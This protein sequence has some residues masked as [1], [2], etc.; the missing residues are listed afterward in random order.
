MKRLEIRFKSLR[1]KILFGFSV[2]ILLAFGLSAFIIYSVNQVN[3]DLDVMMER[4]MEILH[5][6]ES[7]AFEMADSI[8]MIRGYILYGD[9]RYRE[10]FEGRKEK[11]LELEQQALALSH[12]SQMEQLLEEKAR[13]RTLTDNF[14]EELDRGNEDAV[15]GIAAEI[16]ILS[17]EL[18]IGF[19]DIATE[20]QRE[21]Q[22]LG[23]AIEA[24]SQAI[25]TTGIVV[26]VIIF[27]IGVGIAVITANSISRPIRKVM[28]RMDE[29]ADGKLDQ[30]PLLLDKQDETGQL[31]EGLNTMQKKMQGLLAKVKTLSG[32]VSS[33]SEELTQSANEV[34][35]SAEQVAQTMEE[36]ASGAETQSHRATDLAM[37]MQEFVNKIA[38]SSE[39]GENVKTST[40]QVL[41]LTEEGKQLMNASEAQMNDI[42]RI[43]HDAV[44]KVERLDTYSG[45]VSKLVEVI[46]DIA[47]QTNLLSLNASIEAAH[48]GEYGR[49]FAI[50][51]REVRKLAE[52]VAGS[53]SDISNIVGNMQRE[54]KAVTSS[55]H[56]GYTEVEEGSEQV[57]LT[58]EKF[59]NIRNAVTNVV[60]NI[61]VII[62]NL[63]C[64]STDGQK[65]NSS[66]QEIASVSE[67][68]AAGVEETSASTQ[69]AT[70][71]MQEVNASANELAELADELYALVE[72]FKL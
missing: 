18:T 16:A 25:A 40:D 70:G 3:H 65:M 69:Q 48:A 66:I 32:T 43:V 34:T 53:V 21:I 67:E 36:L 39:K 60:G 12:S 46:Q 7:L 50:V 24:N 5:I 4:E 63:T 64:I 9:E 62:D 27:I 6:S 23:Q 52:E 44:R 28:E 72:E 38:E 68:S 58:N 17:D 55:L 15:A 26:S 37:S 56:D 13:W 61:H 29:V 59:E 30:E 20:K 8:N 57:Q 11:S 41:R 31:V 42:H 35:S 49:G 51:A 45:E 54:V 1:Q 14:F 47:E 10:Q 22:H 19:Q 2:V 71:S 33:H